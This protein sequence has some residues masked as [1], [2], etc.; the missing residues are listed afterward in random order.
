MGSISNVWPVLVQNR[1]VL[2]EVLYLQGGCVRRMC[3]HGPHTMQEV[4]VQRVMPSDP[5]AGGG[6][7]GYCVMVMALFTA[8]KVALRGPRRLLRVV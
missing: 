8:G 5:G 2:R 7:C 6:N 3:G 4:P 1:L